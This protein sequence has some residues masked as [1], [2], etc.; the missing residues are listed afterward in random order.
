LGQIKEISKLPVI[1]LGI[2]SQ[3]EKVAKIGVREDYEPWEIH[4]TRK[5]NLVSLLGVFNMMVAV[6]IF[7]LIGYP[8]MA[9]QIFACFIIPPLVYIINH[10]FGYVWASYVFASVGIVI[11]F[12]LSV[13]LGEDSLSFLYYF[14]L[15]VGITQM[16]GRRE[17]LKHLIIQ[18]II[19]LITIFLAAYCY[20]SGYLQSVNFGK[21][22]FQIKIINIIFSFFTTIVFVSIITVESIKQEGQL[23]AAVKQKEI[24]LAELFHR[25]KNNLNIV[26]SIL[27]LKKNSI[28]SEDGKNALEDCRNMVFS[29]AMVHTKIY[30]TKN[31][32]SLN[33]N[34][35]LADLINELVKS[36]GGN[37]RVEIERSSSIVTLNISQAIPCA[38]IVNEL[39]TNAFK[40]ARLPG[41]ML[42]IKINL[43]EEKDS[44]ELNLNDNGPGKKAEDSNINSLGLELI[45]SLAEQL[46]S[47]YEF[48]SNNG[49]QFRLKF[50]K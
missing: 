27:N 12:L 39:I 29:M 2:K 41:K 47:E 31:V 3:I 15:I 1:K 24:L 16:L 8:D 13:G 6:I 21:N 19:C 23:K 45:K 18:L 40:H 38:I 4:L 33:F 9:L 28:T 11:F 48:K 14:P 50:K 32:D 34:E 22:L 25:V 17:M 20:N 46:E 10:R 44:V 43:R 7:L 5:L 49:F 37:G 35:Y 42:E 26:T 30:N 36:L